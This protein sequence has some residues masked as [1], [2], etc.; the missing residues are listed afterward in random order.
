M[1]RRLTAMGK[2]DR[3]VHALRSLP[4]D[5]VA[6]LEVGCGDGA[7]LVELA[8]RR[9]GWTLAGAEVS[10]AAA[11]IASARPPHL[12]VECYDGV[13]LPWPDGSFDVGI[14]SHV[15]EH[16]DQPEM[17][18]RETARVCRL[19]VVE[20]PLERNLSA[21]RASRRAEAVEIGHLWRFSRS[22]VRELVESAG[23]AVREEQ[24]VTRSR[25]ALRF[26]ARGR[27][28]RA[29][30]DIKWGAQSALHRLAPALARRAFTVHYLVLC[31]AHEEP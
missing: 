1:W 12:R 8:S 13:R 11:A 29:G 7:L 9:P 28:A 27:A 25:D 16:A 19:L 21:A 3:V 17:T 14:L 4:A 24:S 2:A 18:L 22:D 23:L 6:V 31:S 5:G 20:V 10:R 30:A 26:F 15:L